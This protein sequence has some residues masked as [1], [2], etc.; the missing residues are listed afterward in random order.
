MIGLSRI[1]VGA[2]GAAGVGAGCTL[3]G[4]SGLYKG[5]IDM[6]IMERRDQEGTFNDDDHFRFFK[7]SG[8]VVPIL[9]VLGANAS[10]NAAAWS[11]SHL[12]GRRV[13][14]PFGIS[15]KFLGL[16]IFS[17]P[18]KKFMTPDQIE[19]A[20]TNPEVFLK[21]VTGAHFFKF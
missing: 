11:I 8:V 3:Y 16:A 15:P 7:I 1:V 2:M 10:F 20:Q 12:R 19:Y 18:Y 17:V 5:M 14:L 21:V 9:G 13:R 6:R 4:A